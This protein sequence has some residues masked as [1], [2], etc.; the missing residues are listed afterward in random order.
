MASVINGRIRIP[1]QDLPRYSFAS[2]VPGGAQVE[3]DLSGVEQLPDKWSVPRG[4]RS[5]WARDRFDFLDSHDQDA[6]RAIAG[7]AGRIDV[8]GD[9]P[10]LIARMVRFL[11]AVVEEVD[12]ARDCA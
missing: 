7:S 12:G 10:E 1:W 9:K 8:V 6:L 2:S 5:V 3:I 11:R 4:E